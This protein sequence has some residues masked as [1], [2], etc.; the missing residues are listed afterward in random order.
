MIDARVCW[1]SMYICVNSLIPYNGGQL[2]YSIY[3]LLQSASIWSLGSVSLATPSVSLRRVFSGDF[4]GRGCP[5]GGA[6]DAYALGVPRKL[7]VGGARI[8]AGFRGGFGRGATGNVAVGGFEVVVAVGDPRF[9]IFPPASLTVVL[10]DVVAVFFEVVGVD[11]L[12]SVVLVDVAER[13]PLGDKASELLCV[14]G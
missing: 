1:K 12:D 4:G 10:V 2:V 6:G 14:D 3:S 9:E 11:S 8:D 5:R 13:V 7:S